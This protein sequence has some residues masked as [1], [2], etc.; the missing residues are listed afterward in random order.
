MNSGKATF[1]SYSGAFTGKGAYGNGYGSGS[2][3]LNGYALLNFRASN[4]SDLY[5][6]NTVQVPSFQTLII[7]K[8]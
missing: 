4:S 1:Q 5:S 2:G 6:G 7:I 3:G 8:V